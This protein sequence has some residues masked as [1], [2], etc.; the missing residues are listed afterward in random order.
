M[1][2]RILVSGCLVCVCACGIIYT[3]Y[4]YWILYIRKREIAEANKPNFLIYSFAYFVLVYLQYIDCISYI[5]IYFSF[6]YLFILDMTT[7]SVKLQQQ[8]QEKPQLSPSMSIDSNQLNIECYYYYII[9]FVQNVWK[10]LYFYIS[11][12]A[13]VFPSLS[14]PPSHIFHNGAITLPSILLCF[15][16]ISFA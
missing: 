13:S 11:L 16:F 4:I 6:I 8:S 7:I 15:L 14:L 12:F 10:I 2:A 9:F 1:L 5:L 3:V